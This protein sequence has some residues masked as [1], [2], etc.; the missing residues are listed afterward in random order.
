MRT[1]LIAALL[2]GTAWSAAH[3]D[4]A[5]S[6]VASRPLRPWDAFDARFK[7]CAGG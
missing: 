7:G 2:A 4:V 3:A 6:S 1:L 5:T